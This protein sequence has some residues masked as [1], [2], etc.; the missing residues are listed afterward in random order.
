MLC[1]WQDP[2]YPVY[3]DSSVIMGMTG[4]YNDSSKSFDNIQYMSCRPENHF[5][6]DLSKVRWPPL[7]KLSCLVLSLLERAQLN[8]KVCLLQLAGRLPYACLQIPVKDS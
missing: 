1:F 6:P 8:Y 3:V 2:S 4:S 7:L 5:F